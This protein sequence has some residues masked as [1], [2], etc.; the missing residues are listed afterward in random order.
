MKKTKPSTKTPMVG[1]IMGTS[2]KLSSSK[3]EGLVKNKKADKEESEGK[4][5]KPKKE[6][7]AKG[8]ST[9]A[10]NY[11]FP[12]GCDSAKDRK[13]FRTKVRKSLESFNNRLA[14]AKSGKGKESEKTINKELAAFK[15][16]VYLSST[17][18]E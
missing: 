13:K 18:G 7:K 3:L 2:K 8:E 1:K 6:K 9:R 4:K 5:V 10:T 17:D 14:E 15:A 16:E 12:K 11:N